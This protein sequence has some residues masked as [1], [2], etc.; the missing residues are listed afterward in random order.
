MDPDIVMSEDEAH[1]GH[2][3]GT[4]GFSTMAA[5]YYPNIESFPGQVLLNP[6]DLSPRREIEFTR[7]FAV[8]AGR[9]AERMNEHIR[10]GITKHTDMVVGSALQVQPNPDWDLLPN[11]TPEQQTEFADQCRAQFNNWA[12]DPALTADAEGHYDFGGLMWLAFRNVSGPDAETFGLILED[13]QRAAKLGANWAT[14]INVINPARVRTPAAYAAQEMNL[15][16][17]QGKQLDEWGRWEGLYVL[18]HEPFDPLK[19][20]ETLDDFI[21]VPRVDGNGR[22]Q[23]WHH[24]EKTRGGSQRGLSALVTS[25]RHITMLDKFDDATLGAAILDSLMAI[26]VKSNADPQTVRDRL[27]PPRAGAV[28]QWDA[29]LGFY[30]KAKIRVGGKR[31]VVL[32]DGDELK[33]DGT[34]RAAQDPTKF[35]NLFLRRLASVTGTTFEQLANNWSDANYS[36]TRAALLDLWRGILRIRR[37]FVNVA[38]LIYTA[39]IDE[40]IRKG[41]IQLPESAPPFVQ[42][43]Y[44]YCRCSWM[45]PGMGQIDPLKEA[46]ANDI[47]LR[48][49]TTNRQIIWA[50]DS[51]DYYDGFEQYATE[52][53]EADELST[54]KGVEFRL[55]MPMPGQAASNDPTAPGAAA[56]TSTSDQSAARQKENA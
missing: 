35:V 41:R 51:R 10:S 40:A 9:H 7:D 39:V 31:I 14:F 27:A 36:A 28:S 11:F 24:F 56:D 33:M 18:T 4:G 5:R 3:I 8:R 26:S 30:E 55:D 16:I 1:S 48:N 46:Q 6:I 44:A 42:N 15:G 53:Q 29:R 34:N 17:F 37:M 43:R 2:V 50:D 25:L 13:E 32:P 22:P 19:P 21:F 47:N 49:K 12:Y 38:S 54:D 52:L 45:G 23:A 20:G